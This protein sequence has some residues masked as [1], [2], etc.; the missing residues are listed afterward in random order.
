MALQLFTW[1]MTSEKEGINCPGTFRGG[2]ECHDFWS[3]RLQCKQMSKQ[4]LL[5]LV[6]LHSLQ[7]T[8]TCL[9]CSEYLC[10]NEIPPTF[11][12]PA[13]PGGAGA[14]LNLIPP[15]FSARGDTWLVLQVLQVTCCDFVRSWTRSQAGQISC[16]YQLR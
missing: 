4:S 11:A 16:S 13:S 10:L 14:V 1:P 7:K 2:E 12:P 3:L 8:H 5:A 15:R 6:F 9:S